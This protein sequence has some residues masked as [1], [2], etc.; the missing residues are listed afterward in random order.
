MTLSIDILASR[1]VVANHIH[2]SSS[3]SRAYKS[4]RGQTRTT[5]NDV[6]MYSMNGVETRV[7]ADPVSS[8]QERIVDAATERG[9]SAEGSDLDRKGGINKTVEFEI[10][11]YS[12]WRSGLRA[13]GLAF[14][15][16]EITRVDTPSLLT[17][18]Y[19]TCCE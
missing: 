6:A 9:E 8:S 2:E 16:W 7:N 17:H 5:T 4:S 11:E 18:G 3:Q 12:V 14:K 19:W 13:L 10:H 15:G 1:L